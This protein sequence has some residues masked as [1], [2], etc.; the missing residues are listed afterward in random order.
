MKVLP[1]FQFEKGVVVNQRNLF[2]Y[3][4]LFWKDNFQLVHLIDVTRL[5]RRRTTP[6]LLVEEKYQMANTKSFERA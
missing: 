2:I 3:Y 5:P 6:L 4:F 1:V